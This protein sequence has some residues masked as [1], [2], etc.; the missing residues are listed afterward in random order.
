M[1]LRQLEYFVTVADFGSINKAAEALFTSQP[2]V[3]KVINSF[4]RELNVE[5]FTRNNKGVR[6]TLKGQ[7]IYDY[8]KTILKNSDIISYLAKNKSKNI[9]R[10]SCYPSHVISRV[11]CDYYNK[12]SYNNLKIEVLEGNVEQIVDNVQN[13]KSEIGIVYIS[14]DKRC[15]F[16]HTLQHKGMEFEV[17]A[18]KKSCIYVGKNNPFYNKN[19]ISIDELSSLKFVQP[20]KDFFSMEQYLEK[21]KFINENSFDSIITTNSDNLLIDLLLT[22]ELA[23]FGIK[24][25]KEEYYQYDIKAIDIID[26]ENDLVIG[27]I[28]RKEEKISKECSLFL[29]LLKT[30]I[31]Y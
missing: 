2:N 27:Y 19:S 11:I 29:S 22:T 28:K 16:N 23:T 25:L 7:E 21:R 24:L 12:Y 9:L 3:S 10:I 6:L 14:Q 30:I 17:L 13:N 20:I 5:L 31:N 8:A 26:Y 18:N 1:E 15:C 4:E